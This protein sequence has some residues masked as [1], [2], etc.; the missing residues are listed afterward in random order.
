[1]ATSVQWGVTVTSMHCHSVSPI[2]VTQAGWPVTS[3]T[4]VSI[5]DMHS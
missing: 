5:W 1:M 3:R 4:F 2:S